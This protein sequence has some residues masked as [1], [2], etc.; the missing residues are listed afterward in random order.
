LESQDK[1]NNQNP[2]LLIFSSFNFLQHNQMHELIF[3]V[4]AQAGDGM[5]PLFKKQLGQGSRNVA[6]IT[7]Q[8]AM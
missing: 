8:L 5:Q 7:K 2:F 6:T 3:H 1:L 4:F